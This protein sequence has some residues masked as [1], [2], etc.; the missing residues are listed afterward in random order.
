M[1]TRVRTVVWSD[2]AQRALDEVI[3]YTANDSRSAA[4]YV[5]EA[6]LDAAASLATLS[7]FPARSKIAARGSQNDSRIHHGWRRGF[8]SQNR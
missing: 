7:E 2:S 8:P 5:L 1:A 6:A 3:Q 4:A